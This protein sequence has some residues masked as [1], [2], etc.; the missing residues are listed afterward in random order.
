VR[1]GADIDRALQAIHDRAWLHGLGW[2]WIS[3]AGSLLDRGIVD[4]TVRFPER[5]VFEGAAELV[6]PLVQDPE[7]RKALATDGEAVDTRIVVPDLTGEEAAQ[8]ASAKEQGRRELEPEALI[9]RAAADQRLA[10]DLVER[11]GV[12]R[13]TAM[14][15]VQARH[16]GVLSP[17]LL[18]Y[19][20][21][22]GVVTVREV[23]ADPGRFIGETLADPIEGVSY[24]YCKAMIM[25]S[26]PLRSHI[27]P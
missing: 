20:D 13:A 10:D 1:D 12:P 6:P 21:H 19:T 11:T 17:D 16:R 3:E 26:E 9:K 22:Q 23:L 15:Q 2:Y 7:A 25:R 24:G 5:L 14:R 18:L 27:Y 8:V 4:A